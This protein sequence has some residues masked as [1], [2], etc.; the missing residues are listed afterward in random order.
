MP[1]TGS[2]IAQTRL[3][4][5]DLHSPGQ[6]AIIAKEEHLDRTDGVL[7]TQPLILASGSPRRRAFLEALGLP[8]S[9]QVADVEEETQE[10]EAPHALVAR[11][12]L[13]KALVVATARPSAVVIGADTIVTLDD[14]LLG[15][16]EGPAEAAAMLRRL[17][18]RAHVVYTGVAVCPPGGGTPLT[19]VV[20][21]T[22]WMRAYS[23]DEVAAYVASGDPL[24]KA[25]AYAIQNGSFHPVE[26]MRGCY[27][28]VM[29]LP[30]QALADLLAVVGIRPLVA[31]AAACAAH[32]GMP[33]CGGRDRVYETD[34]LAL[35]VP[36]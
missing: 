25:G 11:L 12:S 6:S 27:T 31:A 14:E 17:R 30:L 35:H 10:G 24:D 22:V 19:A 1:R 18:S 16:P 9:I 28:S 21:S 3:P 26:R 32:T 4:V 29:G 34:E 15:K 2:I 36:L 13:E 20:A 8:F 23:E 5:K 33:C 7:L